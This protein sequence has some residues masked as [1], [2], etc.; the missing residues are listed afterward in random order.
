M[1]EKDWTAPVGALYRFNADQTIHEM[2]SHVICSNGTGWSPDGRTMYHTESFRYSIF[3]Y[4]F[5][6]ATGLIANRRI[7]AEVDHSSGAFPDGLTVDADGGVWSNHVGVGRVVRYDPAGKIERAVTLPVPRATGCTF[8]GADLDILYVTS[9]RETM[10][11]QQLREA[12]MS[13]SLFAVNTGLRGL[14]ATAFAG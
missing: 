1:G 12:P 6:T 14:P 4:D 2:R 10:N 5:D 9:A 13:G 7:F 3:A 8:G 11:P